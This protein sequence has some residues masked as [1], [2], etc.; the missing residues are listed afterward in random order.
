M[1]ATETVFSNFFNPNEKTN[2]NS[3]STRTKTGLISNKY[4]I[5]IR[6]NFGPQAARNVQEL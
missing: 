5:N 2:H 1:K 3:L 6:D 4:T